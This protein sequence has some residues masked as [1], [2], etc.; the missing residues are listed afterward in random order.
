MNSICLILFV[1]QVIVLT[2]I[3]EVFKMFFLVSLPHLATY[4]FLIFSMND[5][6]LGA[7]ID[8]SNN[9]FHLVFRTHGVRES[10]SLTTRPD[11]RPSPMQFTF[12]T[13]NIVSLKKDYIKIPIF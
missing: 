11:L 7:E 3:S 6:E 5:P 13:F 8:P 10:S 4:I 1:R 9:H 2:E 12:K